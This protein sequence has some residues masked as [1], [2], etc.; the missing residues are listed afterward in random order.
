[1]S[2]GPY[3]LSVGA[4]PL[5]SGS[6]ALEIRGSIHRK[7]IVGGYDGG[8]HVKPNEGAR[9]EQE[10]QSRWRPT[11]KQLLWA[12]GIVIA[13]AALV[14]LVRLG[15]D[16]AWTGFG[17]SEVN[18]AVQPA[19]TLWDWLGLL[20]VPVVL[21]V[22][23]YLFNSS[24]N[25]ATQRAA[26]RQARA[27]ALQAYLDHMSDMLTPKKDQASLSDEHPPAAWCPWHGRGR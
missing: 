6:K 14:V 15:Y 25:R 7:F 9:V 21:A 18:Q 3:T 2:R 4:L 20:I 27:D 8:Q 5:S 19:K 16:H 22:G 10:E 26:E 17:Q 1:V 23:G 13:L 11:R 24:Q 12:G